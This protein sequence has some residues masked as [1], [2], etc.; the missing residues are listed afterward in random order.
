MSNIAKLEFPALNISG[1]NY[2]AW[3]AHVKRHLKSMGVLETINVNNNCSEQEKAKA[4]VFLHKHI[5]GMLQFE[6]SNCDDP[7]ALWKD[8]QERFNHQKAVLLPA[9]RDEW[10]NLRL[11]DFK[12]VNDYTSALFRICSILR[13]CGQNVTKEDMLEKTFSTFHASNAGLQ[14]Y[15]RV[16][17][18]ERYSDLNALLLVAEKNNEALMKNHLAR[19]T[20]STALLEANAISRN[21]AKT[22]KHTRGRGHGRGR[23]D[24][25]RFNHPFKWNN[26]YNGRGRGRGRGRSQRA[27]N[28]HNLQNENQQ[29]KF[30]N[31][32]GTSQHNDNSCFRC[33]SKNHWSKACRTPSHLCKLYQ[34]S[35]KEKDKE[36]NHVDKFDDANA[37][38][39][40]LDFLPNLEI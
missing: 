4:D 7:S 16:Q 13:F 33:G 22:F 17:G 8:L 32:V 3:T 20:G 15:L 11:Q 29:Y 18:F 40:N 28:Y 30:Q 5:D 10:S 39:N 2:M 38:L 9:A 35:L 27:N 24:K 21:D 31:E 12:K 19:P 14:T 34:A 26:N 25:N 23:F 1:E 37:E 6:Y 36:V